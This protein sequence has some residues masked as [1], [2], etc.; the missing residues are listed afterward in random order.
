MASNSQHVD[1]Q[2]PGAAPAGHSFDEES[3]ADPDE[4]KD[5]QRQALELSLKD[6]N[7]D[8]AGLGTW[9]TKSKTF[10]EGF[11]DEEALCTR[12]RSELAFLALR[13]NDKAM[14]GRI[15]KAQTMQSAD[16][17]KELLAGFITSGLAD[18][19]QTIEESTANIQVT[20]V[21][22]KMASALLASGVLT[23][24]NFVTP[25]GT[26]TGRTPAAQVQDDEP[27]QGLSA[28]APT[29]ALAP[30]L[31][32]DAPAP[33][34]GPAAAVHAPAPAG[35]ALGGV[36][37]DPAFQQ[38]QVLQMVMQQMDQQR[39][40][41]AR[42]AEL[43]EARHAALLAQYREDSAASA[44]RL[45]AMEASIAATSSGKGK[46]G[47]K[48]EPERNY[49]EHYD[50]IVSPDGEIRRN[51]WDCGRKP[52]DSSA[53]RV[54]DLRRTQIYDA[55]RGTEGKV[56]N[57]G[58]YHEFGN[59]YSACSFL[60][61]TGT[62]LD[63]MMP[64]LLAEDTSPELRAGILERLSNTIGGV[65][66]MLNRRVNYI[67]LLV[68]KDNPG[69]NEEE[70]RRDSAMLA[71]INRRQ[72]L[73]ENDLLGSDCEIDKQMKEYMEDIGNRIDDNTTRSIARSAGEAA[74]K[75]AG[76]GKDIG[77][78]KRADTVRQTTTVSATGNAAR[79]LTATS[80]TAAATGGRR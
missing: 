27:E 40:Q 10:P 51:E 72:D 55:L 18:A 6:S 45:A 73:G 39:L 4:F 5:S 80:A 69:R 79:G 38:A 46:K 17:G 8:F 48:D 76:V 31:I 53:P 64:V 33:A 20:P 35:A 54:L 28:P 60:W 71:F 67:Q 62:Y 58:R 11:P 2:R 29:P 44:E 78:L 14:M 15:I 25:T 24:G 59:S 41:A 3:V 30:E 65:Y 43:A 9:L 23:G 21:Q 61:D 75:A 16:T 36:A 1:D 19:L 26:A 50:G 66:A 70:K 12:T 63:D 7:T 57:P 13:L 56:K 52:G 49:V 68:R 32:L 74:A 42:D 77:R 47:K 34:P 22:A 37:Q